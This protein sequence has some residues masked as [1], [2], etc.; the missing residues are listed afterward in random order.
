[1]LDCELGQRW[2]R[3]RQQAAAMSSGTTMSYATSTD[4]SELERGNERSSPRRRK[5][6]PASCL[7]VEVE[8]I[9]GEEQ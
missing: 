4:S 1:M 9:D 7:G 6:G 2:P 3:R 5:K 8:Q